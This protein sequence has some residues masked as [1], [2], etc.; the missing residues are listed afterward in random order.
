VS[1]AICF[2]LSRL[3]L[4]QRIGAARRR[5]GTECA[6]RLAALR[7][8]GPLRAAADAWPLDIHERSVP[9]HG[10]H[11]GV[12]SIAGDNPSRNLSIPEAVL[13]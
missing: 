8:A 6:A 12:A 9:F 7:A 10:F 3:R 5:S 4:H 1:A 13:W 2:L 11:L